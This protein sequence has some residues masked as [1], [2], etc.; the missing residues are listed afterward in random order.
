LKKKAARFAAVTAM[1]LGSLG[2]VVLGAGSASA[3]TVHPDWYWCNLGGFERVC[4]QMLYDMPLLSPSNKFIIM[5]SEGDWITVKCYYEGGSDGYTD[6]VT[7][8][9]PT[10]D[11]QGHVDDA[12]INLFGHVPPAIGLPH[13][14]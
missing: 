1:A 8:T 14:G 11:V 4:A 6:H 12:A 5:L 10:G 3:A 7:W 9:G 13:C 2:T